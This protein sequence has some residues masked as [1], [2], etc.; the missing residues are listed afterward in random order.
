MREKDSALSDHSRFASSEVE[1][2]LAANGVRDLESAFQVGQARDED[3]DGLA[4]RRWNRRVMKLDL[5]DSAG[6]AVYIKRQWQAERL[7]PRPTDLRHRI[8]IFCAPIHEWH[9]LQLL[10]D[11]GFHV[12]QP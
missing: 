3:H 7:F 10:Q 9:G 11:A 12:S 1:R 4:R 8:R 2:L 5:K 6:A